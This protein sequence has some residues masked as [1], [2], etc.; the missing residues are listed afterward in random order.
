[1]TEV[2]GEV[3]LRDV[4]RQKYLNYAL[5]VI[6]SRALPDVRD[7]L[8]PVQR[9]ILYAMYKDLRLLPERKELKCAKVVGEVLGNYHP[10]GDSAVYEALVRMAQDFSLRVPL[11]NGHG[12]FGSIDGDSA[13]AYRYTEAKLRPFA[14][15]LLAEID[16]ETV[17]FRDTFDGMRKEPEVLPAQAPVLLLNGATGIAVGIA[18][19]IPPHSLK[20][21]I[22]ACVLLIR[23][24]D[25]SIP[26]LMKK[27]RGPDFPTGGQ[28]LNTP[29]ELL[30]IYTSGRGPVR[31]QANWTVEGS[32]RRKAI[33]ISSIP[34][35]VKKQDL[36]GKIRD[37][38]LDKKIPQ[39]VDVRDESTDQIRIVLELKSE[40]VPAKVMAYLFKSTDLRSN[41]NVNL[42]C[43]VPVTGSDIAVPRQT[44][45]KEVLRYFLD[46]RLATVRRRFEFELRKLLE[47]IHILDGFAKIFNDLDTAIKII[48]ESKDKKQAGEGLMAYFLIDQIQADAILELMLYRL[49]SLE[50]KKILTE[51]KEKKERAAVIREIL[52]SEQKLWD[53]VQGELEALAAEHGD[54]RRSEIVGDELEEEVEVSADDFIVDEDQYVVLSTGGWIKRVGSVTS[55]DKV[56]VKQG[57]SLLALAAGSTK[58]T[59]VFL[60][61][62]GVAYTARIHD[63]PATRGY[64]DPIQKLFRL[65]DG[66]KIVAMLS[67]DPRAI[68][69][70]EPDPKGQYC[71]PAHALAVSSQGF[72]MRF[73][74]KGLQEPSNRVGRKYARVPDEAEIVGVH[75][76]DGSETLICVTEQARALL[77][78]VDEVNYLEG[79]GKGVYVIKPDKGD[80]VIASAVTT[81]DH[82]GLT[83]ITN[84]GTPHNINP[85]RYKV[86]SRAGKGFFVIKRGGFTGVKAVDIELPK[87]D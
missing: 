38:A 56:P 65:K 12:N 45:L 67:L 24:P 82:E 53:T 86:T 48:R 71:P 36:V 10:H 55:V 9:R 76:I 64:G 77:C 63:L 28:I 21:V 50:I 84:N 81:K 42:T 78:P 70:I 44:D 72:G 35:M 62:K 19:N 17:D 20:E 79:P 31:M 34:Y 59:V 29:E 40:A 69:D 73:G 2:I 57:D 47:R 8:K 41:F 22:D 7:G 75:V 13:A 61:N 39:I 11:I 58:A 14:V 43:L 27:L 16:E 32:G 54:K 60:S 30:E 18:T 87:L 66:E 15:S 52:G 46:F 1:M 68:G 4:A 3:P 74:L 23:K 25:S 83:A 85:R 49:A 51:R 33:V 37:L 6:T 80:R 26:Q 5:S